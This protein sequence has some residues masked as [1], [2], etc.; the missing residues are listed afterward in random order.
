MLRT[1]RRC[2][3]TYTYHFMPWLD[4]NLR[5]KHRII[6]CMWSLAYAGGMG[7]EPVQVIGQQS[8]FCLLKQEYLAITIDW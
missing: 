8:M 1:L 5:R 4:L 7:L 6:S 2:W 3:G